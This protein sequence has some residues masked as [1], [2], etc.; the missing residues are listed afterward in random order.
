VWVKLVH[1]LLAR[2]AFRNA[3]ETVFLYSVATMTERPR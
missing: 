1:K 3:L 2:N